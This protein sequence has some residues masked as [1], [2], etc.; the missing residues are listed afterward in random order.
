MATIARVAICVMS[1]SIFVSFAMMAVVIVPNCARVAAAAVNVARYARM[2]E[3]IASIV[4]EAVIHAIS[5]LFALKHIVSSVMK[6]VPTVHL[7]AGTAE[8]V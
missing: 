1:V 8:V 3:N 2:A 6:A 4:L 5:V 7:Y